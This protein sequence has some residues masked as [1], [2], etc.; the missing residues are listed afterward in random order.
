M[1]GRTKKRRE[2]DRSSDGGRG[3][4]LSGGVAEVLGRRSRS[5]GRRRE[6]EEKK[7]RRRRSGDRDDESPE[8]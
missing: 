6:K 8:K 2:I 7:K 1:G 3:E 5:S 4:G